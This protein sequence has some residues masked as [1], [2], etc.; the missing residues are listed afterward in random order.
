MKQQME[1]HRVDTPMTREAETQG[2][3]VVKGVSDRDSLRELARSLGRPVIGPDGELIK[4]LRVTRRAAARP[5]TLSAAFG[6]ASFPLHTDTA[7]WNVPARFLVMRAIGDIR[8]V[9]T[10]CPFIE[11]FAF[12]EGN[13]M[14][15]AR[16][17]VWT[18]KTLN[19]PVYCGLPFRT[20]DQCYG[21]RYDRQCM[22]PANLSA[23]EVDEYIQ[24]EVFDRIVRRVSW[25]NGTAV[26]ISNW[27]ALHGRGPEPPREAER[28]LQ[29]IYVE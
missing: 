18:L 11:L 4:E 1:F 3:V 23:K 12:R 22:T 17:A 28:I 21:F 6:V 2:L 26:V 8:R 25:S 13:V 10:V 7:F 15:A 5:R 27:H 16:R 24:S 20:P 19:G 9:T 29:R 14:A